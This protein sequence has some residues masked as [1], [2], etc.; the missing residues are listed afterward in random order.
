[1]LALELVGR[2]RRGPGITLL[3]DAPVLLR[4]DACRTE[5]GGR[6]QE[7]RNLRGPRAPPDQRGLMRQPQAPLRLVAVAATG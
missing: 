5:H 7:R 6:R 3:D 4:V 1:M 2:L